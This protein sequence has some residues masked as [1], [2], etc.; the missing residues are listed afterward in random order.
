MEDNSLWVRV[1]KSLYGVLVLRESSFV[2]SVR[3]M[4]DLKWLRDFMEGVSRERGYR[5]TW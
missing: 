3:T 1:V 2:S 4:R 5:G